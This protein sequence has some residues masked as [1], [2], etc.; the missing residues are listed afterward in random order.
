[1]EIPIKDQ[2]AAIAWL[3]RKAWSEDTP[4]AEAMHCANLL[5]MLVDAK[6]IPPADEPLQRGSES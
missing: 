2:R 1:M 5:G 3:R 4:E 6:A